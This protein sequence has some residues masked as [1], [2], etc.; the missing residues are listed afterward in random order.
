MGKHVEVLGF[1]KGIIG[2]LLKISTTTLFI[3][4]AAVLL[5]LVVLGLSQEFAERNIIIGRLI[6]KTELLKNENRLLTD[7][8]FGDN[9][10]QSKSICIEI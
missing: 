10:P 8:L 1:K 3:S 9:K 7:R 2:R 4:L 6:E 5:T